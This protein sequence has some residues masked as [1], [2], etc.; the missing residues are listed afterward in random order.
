MG[1]VSGP[2]AYRG[3]HVSARAPSEGTTIRFD[4][5]NVWRVGYVVMALVAVALLLRFI[6]SDGGSVIFTLL[7]AWF[8]GLAMEPAVGRLSRRM[9]R[10]AAVGLVM[11][12]LGAVHRDLRRGRSGRC[13]SSRSPNC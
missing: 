8:A 3:G 7:M 2:P 6:I 12:A 13:S 9:R 4:P 10:G 1:D 11:G 5:G